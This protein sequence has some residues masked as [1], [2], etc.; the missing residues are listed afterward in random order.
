MHSDFLVSIA[1]KI[2]LVAIGV[3]GVL[4]DSGMYF[5]NSGD[6]LRKFNRK[7]GMG[8][9]LLEMHNIASA[10]VS[11]VDTPLVERWA[12]M[13]FVKHVDLGARKKFHSIQKFAISEGADMEEV[14]YIADDIDELEILSSVGLPIAVAD[15]SQHTKSHAK[16]VTSR[17]GGD[18]AVRE[19]IELILQAKNLSVGV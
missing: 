17:R 16:Y 4:T 9:Q 12:K 10:M 2:K 7:D 18:G 5:N 14:C 11:S 13:F 1:S 3:D 8:L 19:A 15:A 6:M